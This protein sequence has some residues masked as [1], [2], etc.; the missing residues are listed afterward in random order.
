[1][2]HKKQEMTKSTP[3]TILD[4]SRSSGSSS[5]ACCR[6]G[7]GHRNGVYVS[8]GPSNIHNSRAGCCGPPGLCILPPVQEESSENLCQTTG[9]RVLE[10][11]GSRRFTW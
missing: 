11:T 10:S 2:S 6:S 7:L 5:P 8:P 9:L 4:R 1:M 3:S